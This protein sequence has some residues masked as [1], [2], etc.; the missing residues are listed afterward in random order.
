MP[1]AA[2]EPVSIH[3]RRNLIVGWERDLEAGGD[4]FLGIFLDGVAIGGC[5]LH[6]RIGPNALEIGYWIHADHTRHGFATEVS[7]ALTDL[8]FTVDGIERV[9]IHHDRANVASG[10]V[11]RILAFEF[12]GEQDKPI[13]S[14]GEVGIDCTWSITTDGWAKLQTP[15]LDQE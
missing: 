3:D 7:T 1:W 8:A 12:V 9:E 15:G 5:G 2:F 6:R 11:P 13:T 4:L 14:P 10:G